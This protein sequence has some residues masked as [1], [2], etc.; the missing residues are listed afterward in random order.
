MSDIV[1]AIQ[2]RLKADTAITAIVG[3]RIY[4][5]G[6]VPTN[7]QFPYIIISFIDSKRLNLTHN[8]TRSAQTRIQCSMFSQGVGEDLQVSTISELVAECLNTVTDTYLSPGAF[9]I[10]IDDR[11]DIPDNNSTTKLWSRYRDFMIQHNV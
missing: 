6:T 5:E 11:G 2:T 10:R 4:R 7:P 9:V 3:T 8:R 1:L